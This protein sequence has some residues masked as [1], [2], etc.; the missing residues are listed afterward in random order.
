MCIIKCILHHGKFFLEKSIRELCRY[1]C[2]DREGGM[3]IGVAYEH[4][5]CPLSPRFWPQVLPQTAV[6]L[7]T[8][9]D[10]LSDFNN[11]LVVRVGNLA[12]K[13][14]KNL[15][16]AP[17]LYPPLHS[18]IDTCITADSKRWYVNFWSKTY[19][20]S[21]NHFPIQATA[22]FY[23][24]N[25][26]ITLGILNWPNFLSTY[27]LPQCD[28]FPIT[29]THRAVIK[30]RGPGISL[31][32]YECGHGFFWRKIEPKE[33]PSCLIP[34]LLV[35]FTQQL[36]ILVTTLT[37]FYTETSSKKLD[38][39]SLDFLLCRGLLGL[40]NTVHANL[41]IITLSLLTPTRNAPITNSSHQV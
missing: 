29:S 24:G 1:Q 23:K 14:L 37:H 33:I 32:Y 11:F 38:T 7:N 3:G 10:I 28:C 21:C 30:S 18:N 6:F 39:Q 2:S 9:R 17:C 12:K 8:E 27:P 31:G 13:M 41:S 35:L 36:E 25:C 15:N 5:L 22:S 19:P 4:F 40:Y 26:Y 16:F 34:R 20:H